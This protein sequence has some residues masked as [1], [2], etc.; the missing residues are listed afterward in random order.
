[1]AKACRFCLPP[2]LRLR[3]YRFKLKPLS[4]QQLGGHVRGHRSPRTRQVDIHTAM[5]PNTECC[6]ATTPV[7]KGE[8]ATAAQVMGGLIEDRSTTGANES[9]TETRT[10]P[11]SKT[12]ASSS[13]CTLLSLPA[14]LRNRICELVVTRDL[15]TPAIY[16]DLSG[17]GKKEVISYREVQVQLSL[18]ETCRQIRKE[19][20]PLFYEL[21]IFLLAQPFR[22]EADLYIQRLG[23]YASK[24]RRVCLV[25]DD[26]YHRYS[27][28]LDVSK[29]LAN[30]QLDL[31]YRDGTVVR[32]EEGCSNASWLR[33]G[34]KYLDAC[35][36][37]AH[38]S[39]TLSAEVIHKLYRILLREIRC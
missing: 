37:E 27:F 5:R 28:I 38:S 16:M 21:N 4:A 30:Y 13:C 7:I 1:M 14:G 35:A 17:S 12:A 36:S 8:R 10:M 15:P 23:K 3:L 39:T 2:S 19:S 9:R 11:T 34:R 33:R 26:C 18:T 32:Q 22:S 24:L 20:L 6:T 31:G 25:V 29:G